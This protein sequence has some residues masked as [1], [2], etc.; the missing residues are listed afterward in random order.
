[1]LSTNGASSDL[2]VLEFDG[3]GT[4][5][6]TIASSCYCHAAVNAMRK[7]GSRGLLDQ[8]VVLSSVCGRFGSVGAAR[9]PEDVGYVVG[10]SAGA[11]E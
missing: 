6:V 8:Q 7:G 1:M 4:V 2:T 9:F 5:G 10:H 3:D 11:D